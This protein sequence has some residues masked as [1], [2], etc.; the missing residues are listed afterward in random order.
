MELIDSKSVKSLEFLSDIHFSTSD[1]VSFFINN[2][3]D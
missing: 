1:I 3:R 2:S